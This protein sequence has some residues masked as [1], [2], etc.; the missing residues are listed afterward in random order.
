[1]LI[2]VVLAFSLGIAGLCQDALLR[3][4][5]GIVRGDT[6]R[7]EL[8]LVFTGDSYAEGGLT[9][10]DALK[11]RAIKGSFFFT[12]NFL[13]NPQFAPLIQRIVEEGHY[14]GPHSDRHLLYLSWEGDHLLVGQDEFIK[15]V[16]DNLAEIAR[17]GVDLRNIGY[18]IPPYEHYNETIAKWSRQLGLTLIN[19]S[20]G[21]IS[22]ADYT[23]EQDANFASSQK[24]WD[25]IFKKERED[26]HGLNGFILLIHIGAGDGR[27]DK[28]FYRFDRLIEELSGEGY[29]LLR[30][31]QL[32]R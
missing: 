14:L 1:V 17:F 30:I 9:I 27:K 21:T 29:R 12:G 25:S 16:K 18:W 15:D 23:G 13:R 10:L 19:F 2:A 22:H 28:F 31:D 24:I 7:K 4:K 26:S 6:S 32:L 8:A 11:S 3:I 5:D 20:P